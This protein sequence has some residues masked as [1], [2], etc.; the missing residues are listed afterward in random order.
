MEWRV[1]TEV[2][3]EEGRAGRHEGSVGRVVP[4]M[5][6]TAQEPKCVRRNGLGP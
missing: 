3:E 6:A 1:S 2:R 5:H 4:F